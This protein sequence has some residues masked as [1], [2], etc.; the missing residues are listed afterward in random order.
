ME[1]KGVDYEISNSILFSIS[2]FNDIKYI[3]TQN[4]LDILK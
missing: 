2:S 4:N 1:I 3:S